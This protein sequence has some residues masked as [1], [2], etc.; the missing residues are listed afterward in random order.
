MFLVIRALRRPFTVL[1]AVLAILLSAGLAV[2]RAPV[3][4]FPN[5]GVPVIYVV[6]PFGGMSPAQM[7]GEIV[8]YYEYHFL[9]VAGIEH[10]ESQSIQ[11]MA[12]LK[13]YFHPG[14]DIAQAM[15]QVTAMTFR[16]TAFMP[17][18]TV[19]A[20]I[21]RFDAGSIPAGQLV[22]S[23]DRRSDA[24]IQDLALYRVRPVLAT[25]PGVSAPPPAGG[26]IRTIVVYADPD[27]MRSYGIAPDQIA[28][29]LARGNL[30]L[31]AGNVRVGD[32]TT[33]A[34]TNAM[35]SKPSDLEGIPLRTGLMVLLFLGD[36]RSAL[37]V[38]VTIP[39]SLL[40]AVVGLRLIGQTVNIMTLGGL[41]LAIGI[42]VDEATV[43]IEN[44]HRH[45]ESAPQANR[46]VVDAMREVIVPRLLAMLCVIAVFIPS[47]FMVGVGRALFPPLALA[48]AFSMFASYLLSSTLVPVLSIWFLRGGKEAHKE[49]EHGLF[50]RLA[51]AYASL[52]ARLVKWRW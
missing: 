27:R 2:R 31:P 23:S 1:V 13:L 3:D 30:T 33:I 8:S 25:I 47:F 19:P 7:E 38:V 52:A 16:A 40:A 36:W 46:A 50:A 6:Q 22:F 5:L 10:I 4:I 18:G 12:M 41:A 34:S 14:T 26:K 17:P 32:F 24:E 44:I 39:F 21:V 48:V 49:D 11:G 20:F 15:A 28:T 51:G 43:A 29:T 9:Y 35:V 37:I 45:L 42:L